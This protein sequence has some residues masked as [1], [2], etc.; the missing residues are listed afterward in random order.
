MEDQAL[1]MNNKINNDNNVQSSINTPPKTLPIKYKSMLYASIHI[2]HN[3]I[4]VEQREFLYEKLPLYSSIEEQI[5]YFETHCDMKKIET[6]LYKPM[7]KEHV[8]REKELNKPVK[9][10]KPRAPST[11]K[12]KTIVTPTMP[13]EVEVESNP[14]IPPTPPTQTIPTSTTTK[15]KKSKPIN[16]SSK[17]SVVAVTVAESNT[18]TTTTAENQEQPVKSVTTTTTVQTDTNTTT[19]VK[20]KETK[21]KT[22]VKNTNKKPESSYEGDVTVAT[23]T[24]GTTELSGEKK[25]RVPRKKK[26]EKTLIATKTPVVEQSQPSSDT[27]TT[28][29]ATNN[30]STVESEE[31]P[32]MFLF[33]QNGQRYWT[34]DEHFQN[35]YLYG[36]HKD[37]DGDIV[38]NTQLVGRLVNGVANLF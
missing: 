13:T 28:A 33:I 2:I 37:E 5:Q 29:V 35:G 6:E 20:G 11:N 38:P 12:K 30:S 7:V 27:V 16:S 34:T 4:P 14:T 23:V 32:D 36:S 31:E 24:T 15:P 21:R 26:E 17:T 22:V 8:K 1:I 25:S 18:T 3:Y 10:K 19:N 9:E